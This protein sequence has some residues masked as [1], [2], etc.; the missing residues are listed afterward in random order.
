MTPRLIAGY[1]GD[2][3]ARLVRVL[4]ATAARHCPAWDVRI[5]V[6]PTVTAEA[7]KLRHWLAAVEDAPDGTPMLLMDADSVILH[8]LDTV[9]DTPFDVAWTARNPAWSPWPNNGG[10]VFVRASDGVRAFLRDWRAALLPLLQTTGAVRKDW[11]AR[12]GAV[13][14]AALAQT[15][16]ATTLQTVALPCLEWNCEDSSWAHFDP[17]RTR[18]VHVKGALRGALFGKRPSPRRAPQVAPIVRLWLDLERSLAVDPAPRVSTRTATPRWPRPASPT[19][20][21][22]FA[23]PLPKL[24]TPAWQATRMKYAEPAQ[25]CFDAAVDRLGAPASVLDVG[26]GTGAIVTHALSRRMDAI[27]VDLSIVSTNG[28]PLR[29]AD[30]TQ[31]LDLGRTFEWVLCWEV[32]EH[33]PADAAD[34]LCD[35][36]V[37]HLAPAS[38]LLLTA[39][40][41]GQG[42]QGHINEQPPEYWRDRLTAR[43]LVFDVDYTSSVARKWLAAAP[44]T[45][46]YGHNLQVFRRPAAVRAGVGPTVALTVRTADRRPQPNYLASTLR[47]LHRQGVDLGQVHVCC[48]APTTHWLQAELA[49]LPAVAQHVPAQVLTPNDNGLAQVRAGL[50]TDAEWIVLLEDDLTFCKDFVGSLR[51]WLRDA[52]RP[53]RH[54]FR[55]FGFTQAKHPHRAFYDWPLEQLRGSQAI[56]LRREDAVA[57]LAWGTQHAKDWC[58]VTPWRNSSA[59]P[60]IAFDKFVAAWA[61]ETWPRTPGVI[62]HPYFVKHIGD[63]SSIHARGVRNDAPFA[64]E[65][66]SYRAQEATA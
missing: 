31:P 23:A 5:T 63:K 14:Q 50:T 10:V 3:Y 38:T 8:P 26:C 19:R 20:P 7:S 11:L 47:H 46:W 45:P 59:D 62:S 49:G 1:D 33:L 6:L 56:C 32:A 48:T 40:S 18:I 65:Q 43:G 64:G 2:R 57:F 27:G 61:T 24:Y 54:V 9:W 55:V 42:G 13:E 28:D 12:F 36:L 58:R 29:H 41:P 34:T 4:A 17:Q 21:Y 60:T 30:L 66:W 22:R 15:V 52:D 25:A 39:A 35:S 51:R 16:A 44:K 53:D 37:R